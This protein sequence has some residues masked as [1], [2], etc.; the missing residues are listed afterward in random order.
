[1]FMCTYYFVSIEV[2][3]QVQRIVLDRVDRGRADRGQARSRVGECRDRAD[4]G[5]T[6]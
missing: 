3:C 2:F 5:T 4:E 6:V 1:M